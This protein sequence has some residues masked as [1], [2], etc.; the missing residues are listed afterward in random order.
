MSP[1]IRSAEHTVSTT[2]WFR[3]RRGRCGYDRAAFEVAS[4]SWV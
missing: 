3:N 2:R 4:S 1:A